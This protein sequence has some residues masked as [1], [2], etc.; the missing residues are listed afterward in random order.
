MAAATSEPEAGNLDKGEEK[1]QDIPSGRSSSPLSF[2]MIAVVGI[3]EVTGSALR[4]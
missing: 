2:D 3:G 4:P 1:E